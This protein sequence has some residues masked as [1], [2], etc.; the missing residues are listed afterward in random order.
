[1]LCEDI[2]SICFFFKREAEGRANRAEQRA[3]DVENE[4]KI[5]LEKI[6]SLEREERTASRPSSAQSTEAAVRSSLGQAS[7]PVTPKT[8]APSPR[9][10]SRQPL[11]RASSASG[12]GKK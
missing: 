3:M 7:R 9:A 2:H 1:M 11:S 5:A 6:R 8:L 4:L 12:R 10:S